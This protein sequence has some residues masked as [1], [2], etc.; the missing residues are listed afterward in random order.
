MKLTELFDLYINSK[1]ESKVD[2][3]NENCV[4]LLCTSETE[5]KHLEISKILESLG[6]T[7]L[8]LIN[9][10]VTMGNIHKSFSFLSYISSDCIVFVYLYLDSTIYSNNL[11]R[12]KMYDYDENKIIL[13]AMDINEF[14]FISNY[15]DSKLILIFVDCGNKVLLDVQRSPFDLAINDEKDQNVWYFISDEKDG[16]L[17]GFNNFFK[18]N[19]YKSNNYNSNNYKSNNYKSNNYKSINLE[20]FCKIININYVKVQ[21][22]IDFLEIPVLTFD[23][24][25]K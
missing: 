24:L 2:T 9:E 6:L 8:C 21:G 10:K 20:E 23:K 25:L 13:T 5:N 18:S 14:K 22:N 11:L 17:K 1:G 12:I 7:V 3:I 15:L 16:I 19:N 4:L